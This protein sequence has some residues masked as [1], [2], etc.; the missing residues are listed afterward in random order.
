[1]T[2]DEQTFS[3]S[4]CWQAASTASSLGGYAENWAEV[5]TVFARVEPLR[6][7]SVFGAGQTLESVT[8]SVTLRHRT[9]VL[10]GMR[11][12]REETTRGFPCR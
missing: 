2:A 9:G 5:A 7:A 11:L 1:M 6:A 10:A 8:H 3:A 12:A 4:A